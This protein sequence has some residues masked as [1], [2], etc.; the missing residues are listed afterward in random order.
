MNRA[1]KTKIYLTLI[2][3]AAGTD[4]LSRYVPTE[5]VPEVINPLT[6]WPYN[7]VG[8]LTYRYNPGSALCISIINDKEVTSNNANKRSI[9]GKDQTEGK[10][11]QT[12]YVPTETVPEVINPLTGWPYNGVGQ[13][14][15]RYNPGAALCISIINDKGVTSNNADKRSVGGK[16]QTEGKEVQTEGKT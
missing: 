11:A 4:Y 15:Y 12:G 10:E 9:G 13:L 6:G 14:T 3:R 2:D 5:T 1:T 16:D 8:Q 7:G